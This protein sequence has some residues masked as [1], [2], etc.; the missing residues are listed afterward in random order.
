M[1]RPTI[2]RAVNL[3]GRIRKHIHVLKFRPGNAVCTVSQQRDSIM[4]VRLS[5]RSVDEEAG[6]FGA[7]RESDFPKK[8]LSVVGIQLVATAL[9]GM[10]FCIFPSLTEWTSRNV[11]SFWLAFALAIVS[12]VVMHFVR[13]KAGAYGGLTGLTITMGYMVGYTCGLSDPVTVWQALVL[14]T[15]LVAILVGYAFTGADMTGAQPHLIVGLTFLCFAS[16]F[17]LLFPPNSIF[18]LVVT[19]AG[20]V[21]F[22]VLLIVDVQLIMKKESH[23]NADLDIVSA[24]AEIYLDVINIF[25]RILSLLNREKN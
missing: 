25:V 8:V 16:L 11:W 9:I 3:I 4:K 18:N 17:G 10:L 24:A 12:I 15:L 23:L 1:I 20:L 21:V 14:T 2:H 22:C 13:T 19:I 6:I 7:K 5:K